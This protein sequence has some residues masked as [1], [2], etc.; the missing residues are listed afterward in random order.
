[1]KI[2]LKYLLTGLIFLIAILVFLFSSSPFFKQN[3]NIFLGDVSNSLGEWAGPKIV[4]WVE[5]NTSADPIYHDR[6]VA[7]LKE[8]Q[9]ITDTAIVSTRMGHEDFYTIL[10]NEVPGMRIIPGIKTSFTDGTDSDFALPLRWQKV[11]ESINKIIE[12]TGTDMIVMENEG[13]IKEHYEK[14]DS[15]DYEK[16]KEGLNYLPKNITYLWYPPIG[17]TDS[18]Y[19]DIDRVVK[20]VLP[21]KFVDYASF[22]GPAGHSSSFTKTRVSALE[23][24]AGEPTILMAY[25]YNIEGNNLYWMDTQSPEV[26][27]E[28]DEYWGRKNFLI[29]YPGFSHWV[30]AA[31]SIS[32]YLWNAAS[33][34]NWTKYIK[35][36]QTSSEPNTQTIQQNTNANQNTDADSST[37]ERLLAEIARLKGLIA[38]ALAVRQSTGASQQLEEILFQNTPQGSIPNTFTFQ[39]TLTLNTNSNDVV[40]LQ[41]ILNSDPDT[42]VANTGW[43]SPG[44]ESVHFGPATQ[45]AVQAFQTKYNIVAPGI[46]GYGIVGPA[47]REKLNELIVK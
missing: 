29:L 31:S 42:Q 6:V 46:Y 37:I 27:K 7:G 38:Q 12:I 24:L 21:V 4:P 19:L 35:I 47:T 25:F 3:K 32:N 13:A 5:W 44:W 15:L 1:M 26:V 9:K 10:K 39:K 14:Y 22:A 33:Q 18:R 23:L 30:D 34:N 36:S 17:G 45:R 43:G 28:M 8:W 16:L 40:Y 20:S 11:A 2:K 41:K